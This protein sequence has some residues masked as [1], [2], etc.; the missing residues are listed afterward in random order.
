MLYLWVKMINIRNIAY[1]NRKVDAEVNTNYSNL[2][3]VC[4]QDYIYWIMV[5]Y[6]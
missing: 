5:Y 1:V 6:G 3:A 2:Q 4:W